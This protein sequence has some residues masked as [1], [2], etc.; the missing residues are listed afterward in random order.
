MENTLKLT[1]KTA[2]VLEIMRAEDAPMFPADIAAHDEA[3]FDKGAK[4][5]SP[6]MNTLFKNGL[7]EKETA[8]RRVVD[9]DGNEVVKQYVRYSLTEQGKSV[10]YEIKA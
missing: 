9:K 5:V 8:D 6:L 10:S 3:V 4:S 7:V 2:R 1:A